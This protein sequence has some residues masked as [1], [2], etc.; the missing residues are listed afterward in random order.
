V[1]ANLWDEKFWEKV[2]IEHEEGRALKTVEVY[3]L[4]KTEEFRE[5][6]VLS[7]ACFGVEKG[8]AVLEEAVESE[9][10][11]IKPAWQKYNKV[12]CES[13]QEVGISMRMVMTR[14]CAFVANAAVVLGFLEWYL[15]L[16]DKPQ[17]MVFVLHKPLCRPVINN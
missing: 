2:L 13:I 10:Y 14:H 17:D 3:N 11:E 6:D 7:I 4:R 16:L 9:L 15:A 1:N 12:T 8:G 5:V